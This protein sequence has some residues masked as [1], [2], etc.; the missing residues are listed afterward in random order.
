MEAQI[1]DTPKVN[2]PV[3]MVGE[4]I[5]VFFLERKTKTALMPYLQLAE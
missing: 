3:T 2:G 1:V 4:V 5:R